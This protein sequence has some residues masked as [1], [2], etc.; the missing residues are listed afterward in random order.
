MAD[1][2]EEY[3]KGLDKMAE[4]PEN[5]AKILG[6]NGTKEALDT[7]KEIEASAAPKEEKLPKLSLADFRV[8]NSMAEHMEYF[9]C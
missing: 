8:Y 3:K 6:D 7:K 2:S 4:P 5:E 9:V 1:I